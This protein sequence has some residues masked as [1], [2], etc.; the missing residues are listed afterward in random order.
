MQNGLIDNS[1]ASL[2]M[3]GRLKELIS[4]PRCKVLRLYPA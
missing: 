3:V 1:K 2:Q 4:D